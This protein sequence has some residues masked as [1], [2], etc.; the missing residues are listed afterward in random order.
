MGGR[1]GIPLMV[2]YVYQ[3]FFSL[4]LI[5]FFEISND[6]F[7]GY[8]RVFDLDYRD[9]MFRYVYNLV[10]EQDWNVSHSIM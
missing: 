4:F 2:V 5:S 9:R 10:E 1:D 8:L 3:L 7:S 6:I